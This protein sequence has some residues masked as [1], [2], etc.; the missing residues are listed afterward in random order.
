MES[1][2]AAARLAELGC[3]YGQGWHFGRPVPAEE[4]GELV[5]LAAAARS[6]AS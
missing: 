4:A 2:S 1:A 5:E 3:Q 6:A